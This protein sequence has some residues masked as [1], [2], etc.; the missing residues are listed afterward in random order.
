MTDFVD[1]Y[2]SGRL[3]ANSRGLARSNEY[4]GGYNIY[5]RLIAKKKKGCLYYYALLNVNAKR[6]GWVRCGIKLETDFTEED[7]D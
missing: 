1:M 3:G 4:G 2:F 7:V 5:G 6:D